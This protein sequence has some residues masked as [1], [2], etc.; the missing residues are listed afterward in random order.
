M[1]ADLVGA[2]T[3]GAVAGIA[4]NVSTVAGISGNVTTV[5]G[6]SG[7]VT[8]VA[9]ISADV[10]AVAGDA[11]DIGIVAADL[12]GA[13]DIGT[14]ADNIADIQTVADMT[15]LLETAEKAADYTLALAD[16]GKIVAMNKSGAA[17]L[18]VPANA[19]VAFP[20][21]SVVGVYNLSS[22]EVTIAEGGG[23]TV[24]NAGNLPQYGEAS[25]R[26][27]GTNEWVLVGDVL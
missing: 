5:A 3:I 16:A 20:V 25:L 6:I 27:R 26:K 14:C 17:T 9:G 18:T 11:A 10:T 19:A 12:A 21:G 24:R 7:N 4:A 8:T 1:A 13:D 22:D 15:L 2:D 23:V